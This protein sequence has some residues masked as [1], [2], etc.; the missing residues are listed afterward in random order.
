MLMIVPL[1][2]LR[3]LESIFFFHL[4]LGF[5]LSIFLHE[6]WKIGDL[7]DLMSVNGR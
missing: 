6:V 7:V 1:F 2:C 4:Y 5:F 3:D